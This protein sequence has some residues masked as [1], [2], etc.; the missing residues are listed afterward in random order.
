MM[1]HQLQFEDK[2]YVMASVLPPPPALTGGRGMRMVHK[3]RNDGANQW[4]QTLQENRG[5]QV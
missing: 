5:D 3:G 2:P 1:P 4:G